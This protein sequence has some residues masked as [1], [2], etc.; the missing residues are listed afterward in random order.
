MV[1]LGQKRRNLI[2]PPFLLPQ[3][4]KNRRINFFVYPSILKIA[5]IFLN[6][7]ASAKRLAT[8]LQFITLK[9]ASI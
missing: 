4:Q 1:D 6:Y 3:S 8:S 2:I 7:L 5:I 9:K